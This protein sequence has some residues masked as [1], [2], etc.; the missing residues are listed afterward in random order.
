MKILQFFDFFARILQR[1]PAIEANIEIHWNKK[2]EKS[3]S[4]IWVVQMC[5]YYQFQNFQYSKGPDYTVKT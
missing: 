2:K 5:Y 4:R 1:D 3:S